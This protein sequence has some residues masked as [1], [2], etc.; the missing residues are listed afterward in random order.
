MSGPHPLLDWLDAPSDRRGLRVREPSGAWTFHSYRSLAAS[1]YAMAE[2]LRQEGVRPGDA[3]ALATGSG[4]EFVAGFF[5][6]LTAGGTP[7]P[8]APPALF[9]R[10]EDYRGRVGGL[11]AA[12]RTGCVVTRPE[13]AAVL[14]GTGVRVVA[15]TAEELT[16]PQAPQ[17]RDR[18]ADRALVQFTSGSSG[19]PRAVAVPAT[20]LEANIGAIR[21]WLGMRDDDAT[22]TWLP[23]HHDMGLIGCLLTP[24]VGGN[25][26]FVMSPE[27][28]VRDPVTWLD[29]FGSGAARLSAAPV[30]GLAHVLR[31]VRAEAIAD[32]S[33][34]F[35]GWRA[36]I[37]GAERVDPAVLTGFAALLAPFGFSPRAFLPAYGLAEAT[38]AV[39]G[40]G[41]GDLPRSVTVDR[42]SLAP[43]RRVR[44]ASGEEDGPPLTVAG[45]GRPLTAGSTV[46]VVGQDGRELPEGHVGEIEVSGPSV[47]AG[48]LDDGHVSPGAFRGGTV[49][50]GDSGFVDAGE[51]FVLGRLGDRVKCRAGT[52]F[53]EDLVAAVEGVPELAHARPAVLL[54]ALDGVDTAVVVVEHRPGPWVEEVVRVLRRHVEGIGVRV[55]AGPR[56]TV[57]RTTS[58][59]PRR[60]PMWDAFVAG[61]IGGTE[62][63]A[64]LADGPGTAT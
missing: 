23:L 10:T 3:V 5:G 45:C 61:T 38:L 6:T 36:L 31:R 51:L 12:A 60:R 59:K 30:F 37:T 43:G 14:G 27:S 39:T 55:V 33:W 29:C 50:T 4:V 64:A 13:S 47:A 26:L 2:R 8:L 62:V 24:L 16:G 18:P 7:V 44:H 63:A 48:Y 1:V 42:R 11:L 32:R 35:T 46:R 22:A 54:G 53:A 28:F 58:G 49:R 34:D 21:A 25:D 52:V 15:V 20:A 56:G 40:T 57:R 17:T 9:Q 19:R 41:L